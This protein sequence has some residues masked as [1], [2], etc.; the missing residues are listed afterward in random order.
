MTI[1]LGVNFGDYVL[2]AADTRTT[3]FNLNGSVRKYEDDSVKI[4]KTA[5]GLI[6]GAGS[7]Q[8]LNFVED[9]LENE[10]ITHT[11]KILSMVREAR[12]N[13]RKTYWKT[14]ESDI[15]MTGWIFSYT[16][17]KDNKPK[18]RLDILHPAFGD[19]FAR[20]EEN[21]PTLICPCE[22]TEQEV[23]VISDSLKKKIR[24]SREFSSLSDSIQYHWSI[25]ASLIRKIQPK[26][27]SISPYSQIGVHTLDGHAGISKILKDDE[28]NVTIKLDKLT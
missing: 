25:V 2:L 11:K 20:F 23:E 3:Y 19:M 1:A 5:I 18:L 24:P 8:L 28:P 26:F 12:T 27:P 14:A 13:Y 15:K 10:K 22:A 4:R 16:T 17:L 7:T 21:H 6:T 9:R